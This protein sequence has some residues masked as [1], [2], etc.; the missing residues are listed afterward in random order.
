MPGGI[1]ET[2]GCKSRGSRRSTLHSLGGAAAGDPSGEAHRQSPVQ[3]GKQ[4]RGP[5]R[6]VKVR[7]RPRER[8]CPGGRAAIITA[9]ATG[10]LEGDLRACP[11]AGWR[12]AARVQG[13]GW[14]LGRASGPVG[15]TYGSKVTVRIEK[16]KCS[17]DQRLA[18]GPVRV[19]TWG[20]AHRAKGPCRKHAEGEVRHAG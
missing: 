20:N 14:K 2:I 5:Q 13:H 4:V 19:M 12:T 18:D 9:K 15:K 10:T 16:T 6:C 17:E 8:E 1:H 11:P 3:Q 7:S